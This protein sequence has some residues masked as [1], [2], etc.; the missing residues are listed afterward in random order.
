MK[1]F[2]FDKERESTC[3]HE[4]Y[5]GKW[6]GKTFW[7]SDS[8]SLH[9][10]ILYEHQGFTDAIMEIVPN[11]D[12]YGETEIS[13]EQWRAIGKVVKQKYCSSVALYQEADNWLKSVFEEYGCFTILGI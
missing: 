6:D 7:K 8:I 1:Y 10:N 11:Y 2:V 5:K 3:Y 12:P 13:I 4:F 9:D